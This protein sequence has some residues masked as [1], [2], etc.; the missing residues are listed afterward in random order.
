VRVETGRLE[1]ERDATLLELVLTGVVTVIPEAIFYV[2]DLSRKGSGH[3]LHGV[4]AF[5]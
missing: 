5:D 1:V 4:P 3:L 2:A